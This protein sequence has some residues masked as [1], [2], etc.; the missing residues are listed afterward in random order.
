MANVQH[1]DT[2]TTDPQLAPPSIGAHY[3]NTSTGQSWLA[4]GT[5]SPEDWGSPLP[6]HA[7]TVGGNELA[8]N[9]KQPITVWRV[10]PGD[11]N[12]I[13]VLPDI[14]EPGFYEM[15]LVLENT[16][17]VDFEINVISNGNMERMDQILR[18][19]VSSATVYRL[20]CWVPLES[21]GGSNFWTLTDRTYHVQGSD[22]I[23]KSDASSLTV[24]GSDRKFVWSF[25]ARTSADLVLK[26]V[27][28][29][30]RMDPIVDVELL[31][32]NYAPSPVT[33]TIDTDYGYPLKDI[34]QIVVQP[35]TGQRYT[36][37]FC[38]NNWSVA[39]VQQV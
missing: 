8:L 39:R 10:A 16:T 12:P 31:I 13:V 1:I 7:L 33:I 37:T 30:N 23:P 19:A 4:H 22:Y 15:L 2:G 20:H 26:E 17:G 3:V 34:T 38:R 11:F 14:T 24:S 28:N 5:A 25:N 18:V 27:G 6:G 9:H 29:R 32:L 35:N 36:L 21:V